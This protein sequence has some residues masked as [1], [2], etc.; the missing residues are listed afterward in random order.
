MSSR[1]DENREIPCRIYEIGVMREMNRRIILFLMENSST[2]VSIRKNITVNENLLLLKHKN[3]NMVKKIE[4]E[5]AKNSP[6][7]NNLDVKKAKESD[8]IGDILDIKICAPIESAKKKK[9]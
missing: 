7:T 8:L 9:K 6:L 4:E 3:L 2:N 1:S 5:G